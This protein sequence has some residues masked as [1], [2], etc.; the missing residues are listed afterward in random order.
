MG[1]VGLRDVDGAQAA[2]LC[3]RFRKLGRREPRQHRLAARLGSGHAL[4]G[5]D[6]EPHVSLDV[7]DGDADACP[8]HDAERE[9]RRTVATLRRELHPPARFLVVLHGA[10]PVAQRHAVPYCACT[11]P[12]PAARLSH[13]CS[14]GGLFGTP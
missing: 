7:V 4:R 8:V 10:V 6:V 1:G 12:C 3:L 13:F 2:G 11:L 14:S 5:G 9:L